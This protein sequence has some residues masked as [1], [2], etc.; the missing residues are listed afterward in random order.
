MHLVVRQPACGIARLSAAAVVKI[1]KLLL[2]NGF[3]KHFLKQFWLYQKNRFTAEAKAKAILEGAEALR[4]KSSVG[5][6]TW[7]A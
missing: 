4:N 2:R 1:T 5:F 7:N 6:I 3:A